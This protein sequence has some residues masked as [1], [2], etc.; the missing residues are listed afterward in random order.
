MQT[1][2]PDASELMPLEPTTV[3]PSQAAGSTAFVHLTPEDL[4]R[5]L[6]QGPSNDE[7]SELDVHLDQCVEC[8]R[9]VSEAV[10]AR[11]ASAPTVVDGPT[12]GEVLP[13]GTVVDSRYRIERLLGLG[14]MGAVYEAHHLF[15]NQRVALKFM[16][17]EHA[18]DASA[19]ERFT[20][21]GRA[22]A[23]LS[24]PNIGRVL[25]LGKQP[26]GRPYLVMEFLTGETVE[27][28]LAREGRFPPEVVH[29]L[30]MQLAAA[31]AEAH[32]AGIVHRDIKP[33]NLFLARRSDGSEQL[34]VLD[35]GIAKSVHPDIEAGL[36]ATRPNTMVGSPKYMSPE[37][38][39]GRSVDGR[40]DLWA[41]GVTL[42][43]MLH[44]QAPFNDAELVELLYSIEKRP[45]ATQPGL[46]PALEAVIDACLEK[47]PARRLQSAEVFATKLAAA[48][49]VRRE[50]SVRRG[51]T[52]RQGALLAAGA[53][54]LTGAVVVKQWPKRVDETPQPISAPP[55]ELRAVPVETPARL[56]EEDDVRPAAA[57]VPAATPERQRPSKP[58]AQPKRDPLE[59][60]R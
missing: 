42:F 1:L 55:A 60:R 25:D 15:L 39:S 59:D 36:T 38:I 2:S 26:D 33:G 29:S 46:S 43:E 21:E 22:A 57:P 50:L 41:A 56:K 18:R 48:T 9:M 5:V 10:R 3:A 19:V 54:F 47:D 52:V 49:P 44:G 45:H 14:G 4:A 12:N 27:Q 32:A 6:A 16:L 53:L 17:G 31:L 34:K 35:F 28:R 24:G 40:S 8:R 20:R 13:P 7:Q 30:G 58:K 37:Q 23:R 51:L 11:L